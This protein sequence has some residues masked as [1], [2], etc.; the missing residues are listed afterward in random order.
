MKKFLSAILTAAMVTGTVVLPVN[1]SDTNAATETVSYTYSYGDGN[2]YTREM[3]K[4]NRGL[5]AV[6]TG[7]SIFLSWRLLDSEDAI[8]GN[9]SSNVSFSVYR[10]GTKIDTVSKATN[11]TDTSGT[12]GAKYAVAP[13]VGGK[14]GAK[15]DAVSVQNGNYFDIPLEKPADEK[16]IYTYPYTDKEGNI[17]ATEATYSF[18]P[19][20]CSTGDLD[21]DGEYEII[22]KWTSSERDVGSPGDPAYSG[23]VRFAAYKLNGTK[24]WDQDI[25][26]G[27]NVYSS[28]HTAQFLV[29]DF[30]G[31]GKAEMTVQTSLGSKDA[32]GNYVSKAA[33]P[34]NNA[35]IYNITDTEN[36]EADFRGYGR[37]TTGEEFLTVFNG[38]TGA[39]IDTINLPTARIEGGNGAEYGDDF[40]NRSNRFVSNV[41]YLDGEK[42]YA[43][44][45]RG[46][47]FGRNGKQRTSICGVSFV[48][49][50]LS[51]DY[52]FDTLKGQPG[53][54]DGA[55]KY[56]GQGNH[57]CTVAD[58]D[59]DGKDEYIC[60][61]LCMEVDSSNNFV[62]KWCSYR[63]H[64]DA[65]HIG[66]Y[67]PTHPGFE[68]F[69]VHEDG[70]LHTG[71]KDTGFAY[72]GDNIVTDDNGNEKKLDYGM[73]V[74]DAATGEELYHNGVPTTR[75]G[76]SKPDTGR[77]VMANVG[78]GGYYQFWG[79]GT[80]KASGN[81]DFEAI[82]LIGDTSSNFRIF[83]DGDLYDELLDGV[84]SKFGN[85]RIS[86][87]NGTFMER[88]FTSDNCTT[89]NDTKNNPCL[90]ADLFG[91]WREEVVAALSDG[92]ALRVYSTTTPTDYK[93]KT[94]MQDPVYR[95][96][97]AAEQTAY[98]QP[99]HVGMYLAAD[100]FTPDIINLEITSLPLKTTYYAG[101][102]LDT[103][104]LVVKA[105]YSDDT[106]D[107]N[108]SSSV[109]QL[110]DV[111]MDTEGTKTVTITS[112]GK[113]V[114]FEITV[115]PSAFSNINGTYTTDSSTEDIIQIGSLSGNFV[116]EHKMTINS[117]PANGDSSK[118][119]TAGFFVRFSLADG[120]GAGWY[121]S[122]T[123][124][125][126]AKVYWKSGSNKDNATDVT[127][128]SPLTI[129]E[130]YT[131]R[132]TFKNVATGDGAYVDMMI[133]DQNGVVL[134]TVENL[135]LRNMSF[136]NQKTSPLAVVQIYNQAN[137]NSTASVTISGARKTMN[138][139]IISVDPSN[140]VAVVNTPD[141]TSLILAVKY[142]NGVLEHIQRLQPTEV[143]VNSTVDISFV[144]DKIFM[145]TNN[146]SPVDIWSNN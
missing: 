10:N 21:G 73:T 48:G 113:T 104:G 143:N 23:T 74:Y 63:E 86:S 85:I 112:K 116:L 83:W 124:T 31:D 106:V 64:G 7:S 92:S 137:T 17:L 120:T 88:I 76:N 94:L 8:F 51:A 122:A 114:S 110:S 6:N 72:T 54:Y 22:V 50:R 62:V 129:G 101:D 95:S 136:N 59:N 107:E 115:L 139:S 57:N 130:T 134:G 45:Q 140:R 119:S 41:A 65:L 14:E 4:L 77:G 118:S 56:V 97:V 27:K 16:V 138:G 34:I 71:S 132:Y 128:V 30:D 100:L 40:G 5:V 105:T 18:S 91:D 43:V 66:D 82:T 99:P 1:A 38:E 69:S 135:N 3:E 42:P 141:L 32:K 80:F 142:N 55:E 125:G 133:K 96:G 53:Y 121:L 20:D 78:A 70:W 103:T 19:A 28:A 36:E 46:Y 68:Y 93:I 33:D 15:C 127:T 117:M 145:W 58:V 37:I 102:K 146:L 29:Y 61:A 81:S 79:E 75:T 67:D 2:T 35:D 123:D 90:Q 47:Y 13:V 109:Y 44:Y 9:A 49:S 11:Y 26:L 25:N 98:N 84:G 144:P 126:Q 52:R 89:L 24:L 108:L 111:N 12:A 131:F 39:A 87:F 60:G